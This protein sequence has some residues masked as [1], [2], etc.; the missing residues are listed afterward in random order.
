MLKKTA[1]FFVFIVCILQLH[2]QDSLSS[3]PPV[4]GEKKMPA[5]GIGGHFGFMHPIIIASQGKTQI[6]FKDFYTVGF[7]I[8]ITIKKSENFFFDAEF[9]PFIDKNSKVTLLVHP[10][11]LFPLGGN[12]TF[13]TRAAFEINQDMYGFTPLINKAFPLK[14]GGA[15]F[16]E[17]VFPVR[18]TQNTTITIIGLHLGVGF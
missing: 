16:A 5:T 13:G 17:L 4:S 10:G 15:L 12:F 9:V 11:A 8:G 18:F 6:L 2:S 7:P 14:N 3:P 1:S